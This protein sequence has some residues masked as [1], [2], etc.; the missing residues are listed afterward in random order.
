RPHLPL[1]QAPGGAGALHAHGA[2]GGGQGGAGPGRGGRE[3]RRG[4]PLPR[5]RVPV[6]GRVRPL[7]LR[8]HEVRREGSRLAPCHPPGPHAGGSPRRREGGEL[9]MA[10]LTMR[11]A[12]NQAMSEEMARDPNVFLLGEEVGAYQGAYKVTQGLLAKFGE[13]RVR[14]T[15]IA[16]EAIA[17]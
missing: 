4:E 6:R 2:R 8:E 10:L 14:D 3:V 17:G 11:E 15:P 16:E 12:L 9:A 1:V 7:S 5:P 13:W